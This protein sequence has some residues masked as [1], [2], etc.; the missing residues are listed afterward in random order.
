MQKSL[1]NRKAKKISD[2][3]GLVS[4][5]YLVQLMMRQYPSRPLLVQRQEGKLQNYVSNLFKVNNKDT[6]KNFSFTNGSSVFPLLK[7]DR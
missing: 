1:Q 6:R 2:G 5:I 3:H 7:L 4:L